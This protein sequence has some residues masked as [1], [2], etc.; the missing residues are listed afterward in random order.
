MGD[1]SWGLV[2]WNACPV[3]GIPADF[4]PKKFPT[5]DLWY[6]AIMGAHIGARN[7]ISCICRA[8]QD[9]CYFTYLD[10]VFSRKPTDF[11]NALNTYNLQDR[12]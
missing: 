7:N 1:S 4:T 12:V 5:V 6:R 9:M 3:K 2:V 11:T 8:Y 10:A